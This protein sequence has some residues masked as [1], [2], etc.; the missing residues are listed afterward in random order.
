MYKQKG[1]T[2]IGMLIIAALVVMAGIFLMRLVP[3]YIQHYSIVQSI[4]ALNSTSTS[5]LSGDTIA[6]T[7]TMKRSLEKRI[8]INGIYD[9]K[10]DQVEFTALEGNKY[11]VK[12][13]YE[14]KKPLVYNISL[15]F[16]FDDSIEVNP[17]SEN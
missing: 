9:F 17:G 5:S 16:D 3:V 14:V 8:D 7:E 12:L 15:L 4:K 13:K 6:D 10:L 2:V 11:I 1:M